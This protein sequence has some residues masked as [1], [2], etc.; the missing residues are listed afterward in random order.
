M[1]LNVPVV[2]RLSDFFLVC[3]EG[4][5]YR[6]DS[7][8]EDCI[9]Q[10]LM[11]A[12]QHKCVKK[13]VPASVVKAGAMWFHRL[14]R[15]YSKVKIIVSPSEFTIRKISMVL[16]KRKIVHI[17][18]FIKNDEKP[19][20]NLGD[21]VLL[22]GRIEEHK[23]VF[24]A[25]R[26][27]QGTNYKL[28]IAGTSSSGYDNVLKVYIK[29]NNVNNVEF[30]GHRKQLRKLYRNAR[31]VI[32]PA[33]WYENMPNVALEAMKYSRPIIASRIGSLKYIVKENH[34]G[35]LFKPG[36]VDD[37]RRCI[38]LLFKNESLCRRL[39]KNGYED[40]KTKYGPE[41]HYKQLFEVLGEAQ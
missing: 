15:I 21:Y 28:K 39:G 7:I 35:M 1:D 36:D 29:E 37:I 34:N 20:M 3:P 30:L 26:A 4:H 5:L 24:D 31:C 2:M 13:S 23:G 11:C 33:V 38:S 17:P 16:P 19:N 8:C 32:I 12:V 18:S 22:V 27:V 25:I 41:Q 14:I 6:D 9:Q 10:S 40:A